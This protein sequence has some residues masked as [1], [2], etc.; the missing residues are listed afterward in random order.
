MTDKQ[1]EIF[2]F[3]GKTVMYTG[4]LLAMIYLYGY[5]KSSGG[6]FIYNEF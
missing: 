5:L 6:G 1:K 2:K 3:I 4:I